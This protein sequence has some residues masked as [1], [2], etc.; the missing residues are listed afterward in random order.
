MSPVNP[1]PRRCHSFRRCHSASTTMLTATDTGALIS[2]C[3]TLSNK[4]LISPLSRVRPRLHIHLPD[5]KWVTGMVPAEWA[6]V[7]PFHSCTYL[8]F[9]RGRCMPFL[10]YCCVF[11]PIWAYHICFLTC[12][13]GFIPCIF[14]FL[15]LKNSKTK[16]LIFEG[17]NWTI[18]T[19]EL[20]AK[21]L[22]ICLYFI[23]HPTSYF[24]TPSIFLF[25]PPF[26][27]F[28]PSILL[29]FLRLL[30]HILLLSYFPP[31]Q[32]S[33]HPLFRTSHPHAFGTS[34]TCFRIPSTPTLPL[35]SSYATAT[36]ITGV[37]L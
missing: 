32:C 27:P 9:M 37:T 28:P 25:L 11:P 36:I 17:G 7:G 3:C 22:V 31:P 18:T 15:H 13:E 30:F 4:A 29:L 20:G 35:S 19:A 2:V 16:Y 1:L 6:A 10:M 34:A 14:Y 23:S 5:S 8:S 24:P 12:S 21:E 26:V 33:I